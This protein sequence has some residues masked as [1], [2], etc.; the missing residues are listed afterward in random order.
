MA[1]RLAAA[2]GIIAVVGLLLML[3]WSVYRHRE[4]TLSDEPTTVAIR[5]ESA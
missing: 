1:R 5:A 3:L 2:L 4:G